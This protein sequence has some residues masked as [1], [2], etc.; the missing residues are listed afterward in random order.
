MQYATQKHCAKHFLHESTQSYA[1]IH[2]PLPTFYSSIP[3]FPCRLPVPSRF[4]SLFLWILLKHTTHAVVQ[5]MMNCMISRPPSAMA[6][7]YPGVI[8]MLVWDTFELLLVLA[9]DSIV[10]LLLCGSQVGA[11]RHTPELFGRQWDKSGSEL[12]IRAVDI[13]RHMVYNFDIA[14]LPHSWYAEL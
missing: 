14:S 6:T 10:G 4:I 3:V 2:I 13:C 12:I 11:V 8:G 5:T 7:A 1:T 9:A